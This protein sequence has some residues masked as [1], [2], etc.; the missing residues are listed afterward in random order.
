M[1]P[2]SVRQF[3]PALSVYFETLAHEDEILE[4]KNLPRF[5]RGLSLLANRLGNPLLHPVD[6]AAERLLGALTGRYGDAHEVSMRRSSYAGRNTLI[7]FVAASSTIELEATAAQLHRW[8]ARAVSAAG[9]WLGDPESP[10]GGIDDIHLLQPVYFEGL[11][12]A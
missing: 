6:Q 2:H 9:G 5:V 3:G 11:L 12:S 4:P 7:V 10:Q 8:G 1:N